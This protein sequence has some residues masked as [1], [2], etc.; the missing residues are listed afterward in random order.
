[1]AAAPAEYMLA[2]HT[3][4]ELGPSMVSRR[5]VAHVVTPHRRFLPPLPPARLSVVVQRAAYSYGDPYYGV[6]AYNAGSMLCS[7]TAQFVEHGW[8]C[9][10]DWQFPRCGGGGGRRQLPAHMMAVQQA[11]MPLPSEMMEEE[12]VYVN[13]KQYHGILRRRQSR[14][15]AES[16]NRLI[17]SRKPYLHESRHQHAL[18]RA[19]GCGGRF[20]NTKPKDEDGKEV[21]G[22]GQS[23]DDANEQLDALPPIQPLQPAAPAA[24]G[25]AKDAGLIVSIRARQIL[26][27]RGNPTVEVD[28]ATA[29]G[30]FFRA[31][32]PSGASTGAHEAL[33]L[34]DGDPAAWGGKGVRRAVAN[35]N[36]VLGPKLVGADARLV[37]V[38]PPTLAAAPHGL[39]D[40]AAIDGIMLELDGDDNKA[41]LGAN[42]IL[43]VS[44]AACQAGAAANG[45]PL[46]R[47]IA[48]LAGT[49]E[50]VM[51]VPAMN[52]INGGS[53]AGNKLAMQEFMILPL[54]AGSFAEAMQM[55]SEVYHALKGIIKKRYGQDAC[56]VGDEGGFAP[57]I[58]DNREGLVLLVDAIDKA[59]YT[60][61]VMIG[62]D[63]AASEFLTKSGQYDLD[64]KEQPNDGSALLSGEALGG[65][66]QGFAADFP[67]VSI[68]DPF[69]Q[70]DWAS[71]SGLASQIG[72][73]VQIVGDD[74]T[75][76]NP[77]RIAEAA[78]KRACN[79]L[80]LKV[81]QIGSVTE[82]IQ[83]A[84]DAKAAGWGIMVSHRSG[85]TEDTFIA[86]LAVGL[87][88]GQIKTGAPCR[89]ERLAKYNQLL[90]IEEALG[91]VRYAG[92]SFRSP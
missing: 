89:S 60:G 76:T 92:H 42:A 86:D 15:K 35:V 80:L 36:D 37:S 62:M 30:G 48:G 9:S 75:V 50:L 67:I 34:R 71:W 78:E 87:A 8:R 41:N 85:E 29:S 32:V 21:P 61:K 19:R 38:R 84:H 14:A 27:S 47:H 10:A 69:D 25:G 68:E 57:S 44:M 49:A 26:D 6:V 20:L 56:N 24:G 52:V 5:H 11:R 88:S 54:G 33:E 77:R 45:V 4:L 70:D 83:A 2:P 31:A 22:G 66:Y 7:R 82:S 18:R 53:H 12:P 73:A 16:E 51:P 1:M 91:S 59:G 63:V 3:Q 28:L 64:F 46:F 13:A 65:L 40:Q 90:R 58:Q 74:L 79:A 81:N 17:K 72:T 43:G 23:A 39:R 55:G